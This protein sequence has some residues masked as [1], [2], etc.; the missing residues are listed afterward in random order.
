[1][2]NGGRI[3]LLEHHAYPTRQYLQRNAGSNP[4]KLSAS[5]ITAEYL[6]A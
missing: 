5:R 6:S 4:A 3:H 2:G 1:M